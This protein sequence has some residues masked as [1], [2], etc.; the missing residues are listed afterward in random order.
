MGSGQMA[1]VK[2]LKG[3]TGRSK[4]AHAA[5]PEALRCSSEL[6]TIIRNLPRRNAGLDDEAVLRRVISAVRLYRGFVVDPSLN[7]T[8][9]EILGRLAR[10]SEALQI[11]QNEFAAIDGNTLM[12]LVEAAGN[13]L[14]GS[15]NEKDPW[16]MRGYEQLERARAACRSL[17]KWTEAATRGAPRPRSGRPRNDHVVWLTACLG[18]I[19][20]QRTGKEFSRANKGVQ[21]GRSFVEAILKVIAPGEARTPSAID[22]LIR[23]GIKELAASKG[24][25]AAVEKMP[26]I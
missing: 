21:T 23:M 18:R 19:Y 4:V 16:R 10:I 20:E 13:P 11:I 9:Q 1:R 12:R 2:I 7:A 26:S 22:H 5:Q 24:R 14:G 3:A 8:P 17:A 15:A 25:R 6:L